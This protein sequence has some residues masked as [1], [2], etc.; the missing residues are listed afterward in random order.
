MTLRIGIF[1]GGQLGAYLC[2]AASR[3]G[4]SSAVLAFTEDSMAKGFADRCMVAPAADLDAVRALLAT[5]D[6]LTFEVEAVPDEV[7]DQISRAEAAGELRVAPSVAVMRL[8]KDKLTQ[9]QWLRN[10]GFAT[11]EFVDCGSEIT[12][13]A[14]IEEFGLPF[15]QKAHQGGYDGKGV[16]VIHSIDQADELWRDGALAERYVGEKRELAVLVA[17][18]AAGEVCCYPVV[19]MLFEPEGNVLL[20]A[21]SPAAVSEQIADQARSLGQA[22]V[23]RLDGVGLFAVEMFLTEDKQLLVNEVSPRVHNTG[24]LTMEAN[25]TSQYEQHLRAVAGLPLGDV[26]QHTTAVMSNIL[27]SDAWGETPKL[28]CGANHWDQSTSVHWY[29]KSGGKPFRKMG[30]ITSLGVDLDTAAKRAED[31]LRALTQPPGKA[32]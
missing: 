29:A 15:V 31:T 4:L 19:E 13:E 2:Q 8:L 5:S 23:E 11:A 28:A 10:Q 27:Y 12:I 21:H 24:H 30:H 9:K 25:I 26:Q 3:L 22:I 16:Q 6:V 17:R 32:V 18:S 1:G 7:L 14:L 20:Q